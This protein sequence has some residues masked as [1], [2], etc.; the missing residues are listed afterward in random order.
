MNFQTSE[1]LIT[2]EIQAS[3]TGQYFWPL[4]CVRDSISDHYF[5]RLSY[6][7][8]MKNLGSAQ[9]SATTSICPAKYTY[10]LTSFRKTMLSC[11]Y[12]NT[13]QSWKWVVCGTI[14]ADQLLK[15]SI[16]PYFTKNLSGNLKPDLKPC[17]RIQLTEKLK[18][19]LFFL[20]Q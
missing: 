17:S 13:N 3:R 10:N 5:R 7:K 19:I 2:S 8:N 4:L 11:L 15:K 18:N 14:Y 6:W 9:Q 12:N 16:L 20:R 1:K